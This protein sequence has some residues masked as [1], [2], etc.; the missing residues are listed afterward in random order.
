[1]IFKSSI[2]RTCVPESILGMYAAACEYHQTAGTHCL[3][4]IE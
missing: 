2:A 3:I 4:S 1:M